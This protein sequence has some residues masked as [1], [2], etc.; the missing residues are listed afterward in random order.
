MEM[1]PFDRFGKAFETFHIGMAKTV[2]VDEIK[3]P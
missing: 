3:E 1:D 2:I